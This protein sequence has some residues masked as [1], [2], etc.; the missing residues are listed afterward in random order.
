MAD[1]AVSAK[2]GI[3]SSPND[4]I[5]AVYINVKP[6]FRQCCL[7]QGTNLLSEEVKKFVKLGHA[8]AQ[9]NSSARVARGSAP[10][11]E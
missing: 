7:L 3:L 11:L 2:D 9:L 8:G 1:V 4:K 5:D 6:T 10:A